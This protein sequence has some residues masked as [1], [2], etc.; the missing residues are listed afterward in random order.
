MSNKDSKLAF[1]SIMRSQFN[2]SEAGDTFFDMTGYKKGYLWINGHL[3]GRYWNAGPQK[4]LYCPGTWLKQGVNKIEV[5]ELLTD[6]PEHIAGFK[7]QY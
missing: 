3:L 7:T 5:L 2:L 4:R 6:N 1:P